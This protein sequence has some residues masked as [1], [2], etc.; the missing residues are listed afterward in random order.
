MTSVKIV[1]PVEEG[2]F[3]KEK[4]TLIGSFGQQGGVGWAG[5]SQVL[6]TSNPWAGPGG[7]LQGFTSNPST[8]ASGRSV[9]LRKSF[10]IQG[11]YFVWRWM[12]LLLKN[13]SLSYGVRID[14]PHLNFFLS[15]QTFYERVTAADKTCPNLNLNC[16]LIT[17]CAST[18]SFLYIFFVDTYFLF[19]FISISLNDFSLVQFLQCKHEL[20]IFLSKWNA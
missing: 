18:F 1:I 16:S 6:I 15:L 20:S 3:A 4:Q 12:R 8:E 5:S 14:F 10:W 2:P 11:L 9:Q 19:A 17:L 7:H 13:S